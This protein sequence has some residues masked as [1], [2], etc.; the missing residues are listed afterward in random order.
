VSAEDYGGDSGVDARARCRF[1]AAIT[2]API[3]RDY[4]IDRDRQFDL[5]RLRGLP[6][7]TQDGLI[8]NF[9]S[10]GVSREFKG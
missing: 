3:D 4:G 10:E 8:P 2:A 1:V 5:T 7:P 6:S 9:Q